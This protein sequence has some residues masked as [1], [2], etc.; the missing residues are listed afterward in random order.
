MNEP[1]L[2]TTPAVDRTT[3]PRSLPALARWPVFSAM[4]AL[5]IALTATSGIYGYH[6]DEL[7]FR[8]LKPSWGYV[9]EPPLTPLLARA[10]NDLFGDHVWAMRI[11][12]TL[13]TVLSVYVL[14]LITRE[15]GGG[16]G[17]QALCAWG[18]AFA[19]LPLLMGHALLTASVDF[20]TW[21]AIVLFIIRALLRKQ[22]QW[23]LAAGAVVGVSLYNKLLVAI[24]LI[25]IG[26]GILVL[27]PR[28]LLVS[29]WVAAAIGLAI[30]I[31]SPNLIYQVVNHFPQLSMGKGLAAKNA[32]TVHVEEVPFLF[33]ILGPPLVPIW[34]AG[35]VS[36]ARRPAWRELRFLVVAFPVLLVLVYW[37]GA[38]FYYPFGLL[39]V[40][41]AV[42]C[43]PAQSWM[44]GWR[45]KL[46]TAGV[47][48][49]ALVSLVLGLPL[50]PA[51]VLG[52][53][54]I[55]GINQV[56]RDSIGWPTY[57]R[58]I[59]GVYQGLSPADR[60]DAVIV[61]SNYGEAGAV[62]RYGAQYHLPAVYSGQ[63]QLFYQARPPAS[64][65]VVLF[66][67]GQYRYAR[68]R[69]GSCAIA[70]RLNNQ[71]GVSNE[72]QHEPVAVCRGPIGGW[73]AV[74]PTLEHE[75]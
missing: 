16:R 14:V 49:N 32:G 44:A 7:Y 42:G 71:V 8:M 26:V 47:A 18:Y 46:L 38:Q 48:L 63:D 1:A 54:P 59:A 41:F 24:L 52:S 50:V 64:A 68:D 73:N 37:M 33:L 34:I 74:W 66:V 51:S 61:A 15:L 23:W 35:L 20:P 27:G 4:A 36:L 43:V 30:V 10:F 70:A 3:G 45:L 5:A 12:A 75:D 25:A 28:R 58:E 29:K 67:G 31:G 21:P 57:V 56:G 6:R 9:D 19:S 17:A 22:P 72:E 2:A 55:P 39:A 65:N 69:F 11:P 62:D 40:L 13:A 60:A 53:T